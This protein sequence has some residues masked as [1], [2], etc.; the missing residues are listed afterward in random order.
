MADRTDQELVAGARGSS[1]T[2]DLLYDREGGLFHTLGEGPIADHLA[3]GEQPHHLLQNRK[4]G[5]TVESTEG[6]IEVPPDR[7]YRAFC[8]VTDRRLIFLVGGA[9]GDERT[10]VPYGVVT[11]VSRSGGLLH[12]TLDVNTGAD[13]YVFPC[14][15]SVSDRELDAAVAYVDERVAAA[16]DADAVGEDDPEDAGAVQRVRR[17]VADAEGTGVTVESLR[18]HDD[19]VLGRL[20]EDE[21]VHYLVTGAGN[22]GIE[23]ET[24]EGVERWGQADA[25][26]VD[27]LNQLDRE[28]L[29]VVTD[30]RVLALLPR[31]TDTVARAVG[32]DELRA[33]TVEREEGRYP[34]LVLDGDDRVMRLELRPDA[35]DAEGLAA[36]VRRWA[37]LATEE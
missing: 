4:G 33:V 3:E 9:D 6:S 21:A 1:V 20:A 19:A 36:D 31:T 14:E 17:L 22:R 35:C 25:G 32:Y 34:R 12:D 37:G 10:V 23:L 24:P 26:L 28:N 13:R 30:R 5:L 18:A 27:S 2:A 11:N 8:L 7:R 15:K 29:T 16:D